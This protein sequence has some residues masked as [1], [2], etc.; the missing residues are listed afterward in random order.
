MN[1]NQ[2]LCWESSKNVMIEVDEIRQ[3]QGYPVDQTDLPAL[4]VIIAGQ[5]MRIADALEEKNNG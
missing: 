3:T 2:N 4:M 5:L 1:P